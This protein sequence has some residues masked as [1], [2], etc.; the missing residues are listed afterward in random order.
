MSLTSS[1]PPPP[2]GINIRCEAA[3]STTGILRQVESATP[4]HEDVR[5]RPPFIL[6]FPA[7]TCRAERYEYYVVWLSAPGLVL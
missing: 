7:D 5:P 1:T 4:K 6:H 2:N 3:T